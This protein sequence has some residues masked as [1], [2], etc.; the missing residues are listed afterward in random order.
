[1]QINLKQMAKNTNY[2]LAVGRRK[3]AVARVRFG[4]KSLKKGDFMVN[5][6]SAAEYFKGKV[7]QT[8]YEKPFKLTETLGKIAVNVSVS[9]GGPKGQLQATVLATVLGIARALS[10]SEEKF[11][12]T[13]RDNGLLTVDQRVRERRKVGTGGK[14]R[15][16]KQS[17]KR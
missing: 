11:K 15:R 9:G 16:Q 1:L 17:P 7:Y 6:K 2:I 3:R 5:G 8:L 4:D 13:L 10:K 14:A 12:K